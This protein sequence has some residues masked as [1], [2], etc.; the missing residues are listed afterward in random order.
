MAEKSLSQLIGGVVK[1]LQR[2]VVTISGGGTTANVTITAVVLAKSFISYGGG[3]VSVDDVRGL[4]N[5]RL[6]TTTNIL[7]SK[8][9]A[10]GLS[11][12]TWEVIEYE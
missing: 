4:M 7:G 8:G 6:S 9:A 2:G 10:V 1:S 11:V 12:A 3:N 5:L